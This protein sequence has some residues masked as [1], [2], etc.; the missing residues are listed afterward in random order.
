MQYK[1]CSLRIILM[2]SLE[3]QGSTWYIWVYQ[4]R[5]KISYHK[6]QLMLTG[7]GW[8][9]TNEVKKV[10]QNDQAILKGPGPVGGGGS[11]VVSVVSAASCASAFSP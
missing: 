6:T 4:A 11:E 8:S 5:Q 7:G 10:E 2:S 9:G 3:L 1:S